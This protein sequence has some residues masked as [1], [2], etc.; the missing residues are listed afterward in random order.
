MNAET[1]AMALYGLDID[2]ASVAR[3]DLRTDR[4]AETG[5]YVGRLRGEKWLK[6]ARNALGWDAGPIV[7]DIYPYAVPVPGRDDLDLRLGHG[8]SLESLRSVHQ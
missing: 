3:H 4:Q 1:R 7:A 5:A 8:R 6:Y 2:A